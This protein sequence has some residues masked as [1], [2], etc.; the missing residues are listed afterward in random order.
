MR[1]NI[2]LAKGLLQKKMVKAM[3]KKPAFFLA[4][5][6][7]SFSSK[8][9]EFHLSA[10]Y[11]SHNADWLTTNT[12]F[13]NQD[14]SDSG[15]HFAFGIK[16][17]VGK[18]KR[19][20]IGAG[21]DVNSILDDQVIG[22]RAIDYQYILNEKWRLGGFFGAASIDTG[23]PQNGY[24][25]GVNLSYFVFKNMSISAAIRHGNGLARDRAFDTDPESEVIERPDIFLDYTATGLQ[26]NWHF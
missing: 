7:L 17:I 20:M 22:Y 5:M 1:V 6:L 18:S 11:Q 13:D 21:I 12:E 25:M 10:G 24:Y 23:L 14:F 26:L 3:V 9:V 19:H 8:A 15:Y 4:L 16:N 2:I